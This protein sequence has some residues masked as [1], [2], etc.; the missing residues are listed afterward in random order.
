[1]STQEIKTRLGMTFQIGRLFG[2]PVK[3]HVSMVILLAVL[4]LKLVFMDGGPVIIGLLGLLLLST[5]LHE[6][7][8]VI[9]AQRHQCKAI[10]IWLSPI[11]GQVRYE[12]MP[13]NPTK[14]M[15]IA[16]AGPA[17]N[18]VL[19][20]LA[21]VIHLA[22]SPLGSGGWYALPKTVAALNLFYALFNLL[23]GFPLDGG[24][25]LRALR[26]RTRS[27]LEATQ[28]PV[29]IGR[30]LAILIAV[31]GIVYGQFFLFGLIISIYIWIFAEIEWWTV[32]QQ[33]ARG[34]PD[35]DAPEQEGL[36]V[37]PAPYER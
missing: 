10:D 31:A 1:M 27:R 37:G 29:R 30:Y 19:A 28:L 21:F 2:V 22:V 4:I 7:G 13:K 3:V 20:G 8:H 5:I 25:V 24:R 17:V 12:R 11:G 33:A 36:S 18:F 34:E 9:M 15:Q 26:A 14:E 35:D 23:P 6:L 16:A 32:K